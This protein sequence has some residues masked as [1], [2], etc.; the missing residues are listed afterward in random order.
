MGRV[1]TKKSGLT[2]MFLLLCLFWIP[3]MIKEQLE[4]NVSLSSGVPAFVSQF[5]NITITDGV[6]SIDK[7][8]PY[9]IKDDKTGKDLIIFDT[10]GEVNSLEGSDAQILVTD[11]RFIYKE[12][13]IQTKEYSLATVKDFTLT[14]EKIIS[15]AEW[16]KYFFVLAYFIIVPLAFAYRAFLGL[17]Y[18]LFGLIIQAIVQTKLSFQDIYRLA[19]LAMTPAFILDKLFDYFGFGFSGW[20]LLCFA[21]SMAY[22]FFAM[23]SIKEADELSLSSPELGADNGSG[24]GGI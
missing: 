4:L 5:P 17:I 3:A 9:I 7:P 24:N 23:R 21:I 18:G 14:R 16:L 1:E 13:A 20:S 12:N 22:L 15:W 8:S 11:S 6:V 2:Y 19:I 10:S